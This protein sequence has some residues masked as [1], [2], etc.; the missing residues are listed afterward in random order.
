M[1]LYLN[2]YMVRKDVTPLAYKD[3]SSEMQRDIRINQSR[4]VTCSLGLWGSR[5]TVFWMESHSFL[6][7]ATGIVLYRHE[8]DVTVTAESFIA[9]HDGLFF[10]LRDGVEYEPPAFVP[11]SVLID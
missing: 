7:G 9:N 1:R 6:G 8:N 5:Q 2:T 3:A 4:D 11:W 10:G